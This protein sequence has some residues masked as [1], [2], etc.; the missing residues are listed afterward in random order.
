[1]GPLDGINLAGIDWVIV[2]GES[3][4]HYRTMDIGWART[5]RDT[6]R[7]AEVPFFF[8]QWG[9]RTSKQRGRELDGEIWSEM[10]QP[11]IG[12]ATKQLLAEYRPRVGS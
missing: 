2:G 4:P 5:L 3:G 11:R 7:A 8:K 12:D 10:P 1:L 6:C 9:G